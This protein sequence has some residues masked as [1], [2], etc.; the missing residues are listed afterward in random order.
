MKS[1]IKIGNNEYRSFTSEECFIPFSK[2]VRGFT[3]KNFKAKLHCQEFYEINIIIRGSAYHYIGEKRIRVS[4]G[5]TFIIPPNVLHGYD[6]NDSVDVYH[7]LINP[8]FLEKNAADLQLLTSF[9]SLFKIDPLMREKT[10]SNM[11]FKLT[12]E[13]I[14]NLF[15]KLESL[16]SHSKDS[17]T[18]NCIISS[19]EALI[20]IAE[21]CSIYEH[22]SKTISDEED[23]E[24][25]SSIA[26]IYENYGEKITVV[27]LARIAKMSRNA[28]IEKFKRITGQTPA[29]FLKLYRIEIIKQMLYSTSNSESEIA[30]AVGCYDTSHLIKMFHSETGL[31]P[32]E[33]RNKN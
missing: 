2:L 33:F 32:S 7:M 26:H 8:R 30:L 18:V 3:Q 4:T 24:F 29:K 23:S 15:P 5:D 11:H 1:Y 6:G 19:A 12:E 16:A 22:R 31:T 25:L 28:Y 10:S 20:I 13:E 17:E 21:L 14:D 9:S 27:E